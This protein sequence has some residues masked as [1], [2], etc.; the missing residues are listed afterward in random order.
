MRSFLWRKNLQDLRAELIEYWIA[1]AI[2]ITSIILLMQEVVS[3]FFSKRRSAVLRETDRVASNDPVSGRRGSYLLLCIV[4]IALM[5]PYLAPF[6]PT[7]QGDLRMTRLLRPLE[8]G[9]IT[10]EYFPAADAD[11]G[12]CACACGSR[13]A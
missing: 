9:I 8:R 11:R 5:A 3:V 1:G 10:E 12:A 6:N 2:W 4:V 13:C 7:S